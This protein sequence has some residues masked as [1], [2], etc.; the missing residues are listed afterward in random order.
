M[1]VADLQAILARLGDGDPALI[2][3]AL[4]GA[5]VL[6]AVAGV[7]NLFARDESIEA[8]LAAGVSRSSRTRSA[9]K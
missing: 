1:M 3:P 4:A 9:C 5:A 7:P 6:L 8:R 2:L